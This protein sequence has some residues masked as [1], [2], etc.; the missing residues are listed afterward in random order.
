MDMDDQPKEFTQGDVLVFIDLAWF[1]AATIM[2]L[3]C[4]PVIYAA[5]QAAMLAFIVLGFALMFLSTQYVL[6]AR[7]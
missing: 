4:L 1:P 3:A 5:G 7:C 6:T 2:L